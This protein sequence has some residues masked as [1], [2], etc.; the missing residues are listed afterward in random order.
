MSGGPKTTLIVQDGTTV[1]LSIVG[2]GDR[3][4]LSMNKDGEGAHCDMSPTTALALAADLTF[5]VETRQMV[6]ARKRGIRQ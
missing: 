3:V 6:E 4:R 2:H 1:R 5:M